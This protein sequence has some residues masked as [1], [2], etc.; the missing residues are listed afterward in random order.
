[1]DFTKYYLK[2]TM[3][4][5]NEQIS[6][7]NFIINAKRIRQY[8][9]FSSSDRSKINFIWRSLEYLDKIG[10]IVLNKNRNCAKPKQYY[11]P[12]EMLNIEK[13]IGN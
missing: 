1:M 2:I 8:H 10:I 6:R 9:N 5:I 11:L 7:R 4:A 13:I 12:K 3:E